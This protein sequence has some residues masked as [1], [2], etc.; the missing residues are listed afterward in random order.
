[1][2]YVD[3]SANLDK[4]NLK[5]EPLLQDGQINIKKVV[6]KRTSEL[7]NHIARKA[8]DQGMLINE[9]KTT[10]MCFTAA[11]SYKTNTELTLQGTTIAGKNQ[12]KLL[13]VTLDNKCRF[14]K[15]AVQV[16]NKLRA[17]SWALAKLKKHGMEEA[18]LIKAY[19]NLIRP[20]AEYATPVWHSL[21]TAG[22]SD[23]IERQQTQCLKNI[24]GMGISAKK[25]RERAQ[26]P[27]LSTRREE[28]S[29]KFAKKSLSNARTKDWFRRRD[30]PRFKRRSSVS[31]NEFFE[32]TARTDRYRHSPKNYLRRL[33]N[34]N[35]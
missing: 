28:A 11:N 10:L 24:Y 26:L 12:I 16:K 30:T 32:P 22:Q 1:M 6:P 21:L 19:K 5:A 13:G 7:L 2:K 4:I 15:H 20:A 35:N 33:L 29:L 27:L 18:D 9:A 23:L 8:H 31:Y 25:M 34:Q 14:G 3:D 17:K